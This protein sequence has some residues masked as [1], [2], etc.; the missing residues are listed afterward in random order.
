MNNML[1]LV[2]REFWEHRSLWIAPL[3]WVGLIMIMFDVGHASSPATA[4]THHDRP[5]R[6]H[7]A[8]SGFN[9]ERAELAERMTAPDERKETVYAIAQ[10][11]VRAR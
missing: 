7:R 3:V 8:D 4:T 6:D 1:M 2:R 5:L 11:C 10:S 9:E